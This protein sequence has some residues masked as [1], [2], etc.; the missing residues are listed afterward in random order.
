MGFRKTR[1][2]VTGMFL[3]KNEHKGVPLKQQV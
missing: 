1:I 3:G 2:T